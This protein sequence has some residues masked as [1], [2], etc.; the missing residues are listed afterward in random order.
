[1]FLLGPKAITTL[2]ENPFI[3][4]SHYAKG[5]WNHQNNSTVCSC[6]HVDLQKVRCQKIL[7]TA[8]K[9]LR[10]NVKIQTPSAAP[11]HSSEKSGA[12]Y[13]DNS[14][15]A[16]TFPYVSGPSHVGRC[17]P[18]GTSATIETFFS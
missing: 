16:N 12:L 18:K 8:R 3:M 17:G 6:L 5:S 14:V 9:L 4:H 7:P 2:V 15:L 11:S 10:P 13:L 1:M